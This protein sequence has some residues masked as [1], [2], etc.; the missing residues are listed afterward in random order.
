MN[1]RWPNFHFYLVGCAALLVHCALSAANATNDKLASLPEE[2]R[3][4]LFADMM[5]REGEKC[6]SVTRTFYQGQSD[7]GSTF[8]SIKCAA[9][10]DW[11]IMIGSAPAGD[12]RFLECSVIKVIGGP[13]CFAAF[14]KRR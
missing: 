8:W 3:R 12:I 13:L 4:K 7:D 5:Q 14:K 2:S 1:S 11:Q 9:G 10:Q 6:R